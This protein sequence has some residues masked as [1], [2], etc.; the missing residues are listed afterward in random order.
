MSSTK[1]K[2]VDHLCSLKDF[3]LTGQRNG[4]LEPLEGKGLVPA[5]FAPY[6]DFSTLR[7]DYPVVLSGDHEGV[8]PLW[9]VMD[10]LVGDRDDETL[11]QAAWALEDGMRKAAGGGFE[12]G[13]EALWEQAEKEVGKMA[14]DGLPEALK[15]LRAGCREGKVVA[16]PEE[17]G[18]IVKH[19][20]EEA[21][22]RQS[23]RVRDCFSELAWG[24][25]KIFKAD[26]MGSAEARSPQRLEGMVGPGHREAFD[27]KALSTVLQVGARA[28]MAPDRRKRIEA[29]LA[30][31]EGQTLFPKAASAV[32]VYHSCVEAQQGMRALSGEVVEVAKAAH[33]AALEMENQYRPHHDDYFAGFSLEN[34][35]PGDG[36]LFPPAVVLVDEEALSHPNE[37]ESLLSLFSSNFPVRVLLQTDD[38]LGNPE[39]SPS[40]PMDGDDVAGLAKK[41]A[42][43]GGF[44][45]QAPVSHVPGMAEALARGSSHP[46]PAL[47]AVYSGNGRDIL[48]PPSLA[49]AAAWEARLFPVFLHDPGAGE[50]MAQRMSMLDNPSLK[51]PWSRHRVDFEDEALQRG[52]E[53]L[54]FT[55]LDFVACDNRWSGRFAVVPPEMWGEEME[56]AGERLSQEPGETLP[57]PYLLMIDGDGNLQRVVPEQE[58]VRQ[59]RSWQGAWENLAEWG[60]MNDA[61]ALEALAA[62]EKQRAQDAAAA[63]AEDAG[64]GDPLPPRGPYEEATIET[65]RCT[66]CDEC[67]K[68]NKRMFAYND[69]DKAFIADLQ[70]GT[71][72]QLVESAEMCKVAIIHTGKPWNP[73]EP[74]L[75]ELVERAAPFN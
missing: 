25:R 9:A 47:F 2:T 41:V 24:L 52:H 10:A 71:Y 37:M 38:L 26:E 66:T 15:T 43:A 34:L 13:L 28:C 5:A 16:G 49:A 20:V 48:L 75:D 42:D 50:G 11:Q 44:V 36:D 19:L 22:W 69:A 56:P 31:L 12:G 33:L 27:M 6:R 14:G 7:H 29:A 54:F 68:R 3:Y 17:A 39:N 59:A 46:G 1:E 64:P 35:G 55:P 67:I 18:A 74:G 8:R 63:A 60:G 40:R 51:E 61:L 72:R 21:R 62:A 30:V 73:D 65:A 32:S 45:L 70:A 23:E 58:L 4:D 53:D 57:I